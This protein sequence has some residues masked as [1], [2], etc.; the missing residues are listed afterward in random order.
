MVRFEHANLV[1]KE[2]QPTLDFLLTAF[3]N[4]SCGAAEKGAGE[5]P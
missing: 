1:V 5:I 2:I 4:G 3:Q